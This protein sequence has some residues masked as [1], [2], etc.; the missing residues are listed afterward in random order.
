MPDDPK[1]HGKIVRLMEKAAMS[2]NQ[3]VQAETD[4]LNYM[5]QNFGS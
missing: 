1:K 5:H 4:L 3:V 2:D